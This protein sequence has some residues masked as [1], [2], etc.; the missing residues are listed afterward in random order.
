[1][2]ILV[3]APSFEPAVDAGG[4]ARSLTNLVAVVAAD[5]DVVVV[6]ADRDLASRAPFSGLSGRRVTR[7]RAS[8]YYVDLNSPGHWR[9]LAREFAGQRFD[10]ILLNSIWHR[11]L[12]IWPALLIFLGVLHG[13][14]VLMPRGELEPGALIQGHG[15]KLIAGIIIRPLY[16]KVTFAIGATSPNEALAAAQWFPSSRVLLT[17]NQP[18]P[19]DFALPSEPAEALR[20]LF[21]GRVHPEKG[22]LDLLKGLALT[23]GRIR[24]TAVGTLQR[25]DYW[26]DCQSAIRALPENVEFEYYGSASREQIPPLLWNSDCMVLLTAG[27]NYGHAIA[28]ALQAGCPVITTRMTPW[29]DAIRTGGGSLVEDRTDSPEVAAVLDRWAAKTDEELS[30]SR[31]H[32]RAAFEAFDRDSAPNVV[33]LALMELGTRGQP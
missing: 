29:T 13:P 28:E 26:H 12:A 24:L 20:V 11:Q 5:H 18:D 32:A 9:S 8:T 33:E 14:V 17:T 7:G 4:P 23:K 1:M 22:L 2:R 3:F 21:L 10:L 6:T 27:E 16:Q 30:S 31:C 15:K 19:I 25:R